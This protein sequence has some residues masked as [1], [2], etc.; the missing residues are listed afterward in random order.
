MESDGFKSEDM[1]RPRSPK[2]VHEQSNQLGGAGGGKRMPRGRA[3]ATQTGAQFASGT[4]FSTQVGVLFSIMD[5]S[6]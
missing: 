5:C 1:T 4:T 6:C 3:S 2:L